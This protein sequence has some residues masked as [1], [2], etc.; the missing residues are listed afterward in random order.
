MRYFVSTAFHSLY[1]YY[2]YC[3]IFSVVKNFPLFE[4]YENGTFNIS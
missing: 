2:H 1:F 4:L 3:N